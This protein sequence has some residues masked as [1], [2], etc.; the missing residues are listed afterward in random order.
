MTQVSISLQI[1]D[2]IAS[3]LRWTTSTGTLRRYACRCQQQSV[4]IRDVFAAGLQKR[5]DVPIRSL[6]S[7]FAVQKIQL[8]CMRAAQQLPCQQ[9]R[10]GGGVVFLR[11]F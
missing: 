9:E 3:I 1:S 8:P 7:A 10:G 4:T 5:S 2:A 11:S 6:A